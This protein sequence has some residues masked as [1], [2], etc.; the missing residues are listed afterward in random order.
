MTEPDL[1]PAAAQPGSPGRRPLSRRALQELDEQIAAIWSAHGFEVATATTPAAAINPPRLPE[2]A[3]TAVGHHLATALTAQQATGAAHPEL[4]DIEGLWQRLAPA[5]ATAPDDE[6]PDPDL[7]LARGAA[8]ALDTIGRLADRLADRVGDP[9]PLDQSDFPLASALRRMAAAA[10]RAADRLRGIDPADARGALEWAGPHI[11]AGLGRPTWDPELQPLTDTQARPFG[12]L[13]DGQLVAAHDKALRTA[14]EA[15][16]AAAEYPRLSPPNPREF[17][18]AIARFAPQADALRQYLDHARGPEADEQ[19]RAVADYLAPEIEAR[20][21][22][23]SDWAAEMDSRTSDV[24]RTMDEVAR[25]ARSQAAA[26]RGELQT[27]ALMDPQHRI[28][29]NAQRARLRPPAAGSQADAATPRAGA[30]LAHT[31]PADALRDARSAA[32]S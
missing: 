12:V 6:A 19:T 7:S 13:T 8:L 5:P 27:R 25:T 20:W 21:N 15:E 22:A 9:N 23:G 29:E 32:L 18:A 3:I 16:A 10:F 26:I 4:A 1:S 17:D 24:V 11:S 28:A 30:D 14:M 2:D 31:Q